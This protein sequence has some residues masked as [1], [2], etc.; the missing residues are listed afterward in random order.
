MEKHLCHVASPTFEFLLGGPPL[1]SPPEGGVL[2]QA[3]QQQRTAGSPT[4]AQTDALQ[5]C[6]A[7]RSR[8]GGPAAVRHVAAG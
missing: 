2:C 8:A 7:C 1:L 4:A 3:G 6:A 5:A